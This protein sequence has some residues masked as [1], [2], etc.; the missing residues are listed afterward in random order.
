MGDNGYNSMTPLMGSFTPGGNTPFGKSPMYGASP[1]YAPQASP[2]ITAGMCM[3]KF[4]AISRGFFS[5][6]VVSCFMR[7]GALDSSGVLLS[8][9]VISLASPIT[10]ILIY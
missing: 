5:I 7:S 2:G 3:S 4:E 1:Y 8:Y 10:T 6:L 9:P